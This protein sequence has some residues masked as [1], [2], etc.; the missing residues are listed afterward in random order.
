MYYVH[1]PFMLYHLSVLPFPFCLSLW[2]AKL[3]WCIMRLPPSSL[4]GQSK[5]T[6]HRDLLR[7]FTTAFPGLDVHEDDRK[8]NAKVCFPSLRSMHSAV[9]EAH[10]LLRGECSL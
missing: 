8:E 7:Y 4:Q 9:G 1:Q 10:L 6:E 5:N 3:P 2:V